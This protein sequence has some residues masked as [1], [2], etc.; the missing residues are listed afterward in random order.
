MAQKEIIKL[1]KILTD[2]LQR[3]EININKIVVFGSYVRDREDKESDIDMIIVS[4]DFRDKDIFRRVAL[5]RGIHRELVGRMKK[6]FDI[7]Y[8]SDEEWEK[9]SSLII[10]I[11]KYEGEVIYGA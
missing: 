11:A 5:A 1:K 4:K 3:K 2:M 6:P 7:I 8:C 9:G 10:N